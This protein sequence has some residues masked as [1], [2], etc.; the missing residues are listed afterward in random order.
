MFWGYLYYHS[1]VK[2]LRESLR[3][4]DIAIALKIMSGKKME[5]MDGKKDGYCGAEY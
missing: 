2:D 3:V 1:G 4:S 5:K